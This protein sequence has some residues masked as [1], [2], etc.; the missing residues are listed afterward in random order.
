MHKLMRAR[1]SSTA[2]SGLKEKGFLI[3]GR[4]SCLKRSEA[5]QMFGL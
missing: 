3:Q 1:L 5:I 4:E 2:S